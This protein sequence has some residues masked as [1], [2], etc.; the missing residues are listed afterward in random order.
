[1]YAF[2]EVAVAWHLRGNFPFLF[3]TPPQAWL[4][5]RLAKISFRAQ[6][7]T[8]CFQRNTECAIF[9]VSSSLLSMVILT[10]YIGCPA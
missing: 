3:W 4:A 9:S 8:R 5:W 10:M 1:M 7:K 2:A 6:R